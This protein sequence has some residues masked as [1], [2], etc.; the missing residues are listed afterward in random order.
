MQCDEK[1]LVCDEFWRNATKMGFE[2]SESILEHTD[3]NLQSK[4]SF[5]HLVLY[6]NSSQYHLEHHKIMSYWQEIHIVLISVFWVYWQYFLTKGKCNLLYYNSKKW[7]YVEIDVVLKAKYFKSKIF[8]N[9]RET[10]TLR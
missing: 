3:W 6:I 7:I 2:N 5:L 10:V 8:F 1:Y 9:L 4:C